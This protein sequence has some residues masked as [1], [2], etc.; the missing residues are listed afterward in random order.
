M[1]VD[2]V[3]SILAAIFGAVIAFVLCN[4]LIGEIPD[5]TYKT[6]EESVSTGLSE[7]DEN[8]FN[9]RALNPTVEVYVGNGGNGGEAP[10]EP[11]P[12]EE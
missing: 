5:I 10:E 1:K 3:T 11:Q 9:Y 8:V 2:L 6:I 7:P 4:L 12:E